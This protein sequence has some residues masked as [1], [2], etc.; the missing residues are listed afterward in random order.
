MEFLIG[1]FGALFILATL[2]GGVVIGWKMHE[3]DDKRTQ[4]V[5]AEALTESQ[6]RFLREQ[7]EAIDLLHNYNPETAYGMNR[8]RQE[9]EG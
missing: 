6:K 7:Q 3:R 8:Q 2:A 9:G 1:A 5:T 4:R